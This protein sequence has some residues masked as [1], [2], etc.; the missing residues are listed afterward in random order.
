MINERNFVDYMNLRTGLSTETINNVIES[1]AK[2]FRRV[3][4]NTGF[5]TRKLYIPSN[6]LKLI[7]I[8]LID[9]YFKNIPVSDNAHGYIRGRSIKSNVLS[10]RGQTYFFQTDI[11]SFFPSIDENML[12]TT[13]KK[14]IP[15]ITISELQTIIKVVA[16]FGRLDLGSPTS[17]VLSNIV[18]KEVDDRLLVELGKLRNH[19]LIYTRYSDDITISSEVPLDSSILNKVERVLREFGFKLNRKKT[20]FKV[21]I[22]NIKITGIYLNCDESITVGSKFKKKLKSYLYLV[23]SDLALEV[24]GEHILG[25]LSFLKDIE[26]EYYLK[27]ILKY[28]EGGEN[29]ISKINELIY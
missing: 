23:K 16:P 7:Q 28:S 3:T 27:L 25:L 18:M 19:N 26:P 6:E 20:R 9:Y 22:D 12:R 8:N 11:S 13:I 15:N 21:L 14:V 4:I 29:I 17:P 1:S 5:K 2:E 10:H 24:S